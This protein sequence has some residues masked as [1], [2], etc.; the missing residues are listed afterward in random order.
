[1][2]QIGHSNEL[3]WLRLEPAYLADV[4]DVRSLS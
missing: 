4:S 2:D 3:C 1:M